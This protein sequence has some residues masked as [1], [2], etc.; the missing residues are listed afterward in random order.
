MSQ[1][2]NIKINKTE[3]AQLQL[4]YNVIFVIKVC[5]F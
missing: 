5:L 4:L 1:A 2:G 3:E